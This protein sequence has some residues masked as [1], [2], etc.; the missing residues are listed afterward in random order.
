MVDKVKG[1][2]RYGYVLKNSTEERLTFLISTHYLR[3]EGAPHIIVSMEDITDYKITEERLERAVYEKE[4]LMREMNHRIKNNLAMV[5][6]LIRL[7]QYGG[8][9]YD[10]E[11][12]AGFADLARRI[13]VIALLQE[14]MQSSGGVDQIDACG[15]IRD[16]L[17]LLFSSCAENDVE[18]DVSCDSAA[19]PAGTAMV[20]GLLTNEIATNALKHGFRNGERAIFTVSLSESPDGSGLHNY[21]LSNNGLPFPE[22]VDLETSKSFGL[23]LIRALAEQLNGVIELE[24]TPNPRFKLLFSAAGRTVNGDGSLP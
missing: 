10:G 23:T 4:H 24:K 2:S 14:K 19:L 3:L 21:K 17:S 18:T 22:N 1:I 9:F 16:I 6:S 11:D 7:R 13:D 8:G 5:S 12:A 20:L 15:Y